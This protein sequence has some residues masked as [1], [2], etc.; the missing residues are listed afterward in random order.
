M[1]DGIDIADIGLHGLR[2][3]IAILPQVR[4]LHKICRQY[5]MNNVLDLTINN[6]LDWLL[7]PSSRDHI[8]L[9]YTCS[10]W[11]IND[12]KSNSK[13]KNVKMEICFIFIPIIEKN[14]IL[15]GN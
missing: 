15:K 3:N 14:S 5:K 1:I 6:R 9:I 2:S 8:V 7:F 13:D 12:N 10:F 11:I 4:Y